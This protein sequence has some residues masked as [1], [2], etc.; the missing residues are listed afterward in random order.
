MNSIIITRSGADQIKIDAPKDKVMAVD[1]GLLAHGIL[2]IGEYGT[3]G[4]RIA[5]FKE[6]KSVQCVDGSSSGY[7]FSKVTTI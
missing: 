6:W 7:K 3:T 2:A 5:I 4:Q 1:S